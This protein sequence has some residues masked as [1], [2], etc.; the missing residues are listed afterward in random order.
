MTLAT[1][2]EDLVG[3]HKMKQTPITDVRHPFDPDASGIAF[4][5]GDAT[6]MVF[7]D[8]ND[9]YRSAAGPLLGFIGRYYELGGRGGEYCDLDV[10]CSWVT[11]RAGSHYACE[12][13]EVRLASTGDLILEVGTK[14]S[15]DYYPW[16][17]ASWTP[18]TR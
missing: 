3:T 17:V 1:K 5:L 14:N 18:P 13:L 15:D 8:G 7:E 12:I 9:G 11:E 2:L 4:S 6:Y 10:V 16:F